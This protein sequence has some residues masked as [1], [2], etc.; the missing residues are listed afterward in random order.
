MQ[1][2]DFKNQDKKTEGRLFGKRKGTHRSRERQ[3]ERVMGVI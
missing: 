3:Q 1:N 2:L